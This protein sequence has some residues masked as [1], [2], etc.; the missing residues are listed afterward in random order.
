MTLSL[1]SLGE[2][3]CLRCAASIPREDGMK[4]FGRITRVSGRRPEMDA[5]E[6]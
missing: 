6:W 3:P 4:R 5:V 2:I 1:G